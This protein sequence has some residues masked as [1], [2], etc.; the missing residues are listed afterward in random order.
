MLNSKPSFAVLLCSALALAGCGDETHVPNAVKGIHYE[1]SIVDEVK[2]E[3][4]NSTLARKYYQA[5]TDHGQ[6]T[7]IVSNHYNLKPGKWQLW[8]TGNIW[9]AEGSKTGAAGRL[10]MMGGYLHVIDLFRKA[11]NID[12]ELGFIQTDAI[13]EGLGM[14]DAEVTSGWSISPGGGVCHRFFYACIDTYVISPFGLDGKDQQ[15]S[16]YD[17]LRP[18]DQVDSGEGSTRSYYKGYNDKHSKYWAQTPGAAY[19]VNPDGMIVDVFHPLLSTRAEFAG[20][21]IRAM[22]ENMDLDMDNL[23]YPSPDDDYWNFHIGALDTVNFGGDYTQKFLTEFER[24]L[25]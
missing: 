5:R 22:I 13:S 7:P 20:S 3:L 2:F 16:Q 12:I 18:Y 15:S 10:T 9:S 1:R 14:A 21:V 6:D 4:P 17:W 24:I 25:K 19:L 11:N 8:H 23:K